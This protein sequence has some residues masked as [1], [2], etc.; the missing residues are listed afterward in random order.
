VSDAV[1]TLLRAITG[2]RWH[3]VDPEKAKAEFLA[4]LCGKKKPKRKRAVYPMVQYRKR[5]EAGR[6][7]VVAPLFIQ[8]AANLRE[9]HMA[10]ARRVAR[11]RA[12]VLKVLPHEWRELLRLTVETNG[13]VI[14]MT[15]LAPKYTD[16]DNLVSGFKGTRDSV[17]EYLRIDDGDERIG[18]RCCQRNSKEYGAEIEFRAR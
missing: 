9:H 15:R 1:S 4:K 13:L 3:R 2:K 18:W 5:I 17:A 12:D 7:V 16:D 8:S 10:K 6:I 11:E 14:T